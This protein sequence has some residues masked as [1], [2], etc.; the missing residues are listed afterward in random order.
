MEI[1][2]QAGLEWRAL[3]RDQKAVYEELA[4]L[5][6]AEHCLLYPDYRYKPVRR[7]NPGR[8]RCNKQ[9]TRTLP[10]AKVGVEEEMA[11]GQAAQVR[12]GP[13]DSSIT[14]NTVYG[15]TPIYAQHYRLRLED[16]PYLAH[17]EH[18]SY[19][20]VGLIGISNI[21]P[22]QQMMLRYG[23]K[24]RRNS[25]TEMFPISQ[26]FPLHKQELPPSTTC[27]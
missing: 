10:S 24:L 11:K 6:K 1:S 5:A 9:S 13:H 2:K 19:P 7:T 16:A 17:N 26:G 4:A 23:R 3:A 21:F 25:R 15:L 20:S 8:G 14:P 22:R 12:D 18:V 27:P